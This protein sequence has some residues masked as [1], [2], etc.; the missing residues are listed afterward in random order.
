MIAC[1]I[2]P[3]VMAFSILQLWRPQTQESSHCSY[4]EREWLH[5]IEH[6]E[7]ATVP[8]WRDAAS[9][10][11]RLAVPWSYWYFGR[12]RR[13][14]GWRLWWHLRLEW[15]VTLGWWFS[16][17]ECAFHQQTLAARLCCRCRWE[18]MPLRA[19]FLRKCLDGVP[20]TVSV[21]CSWICW[22]GY[23]SLRL[24]TSPISYF[25]SQL[26]CP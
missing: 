19:T 12:Y 7:E 22:R 13:S 18:L 21:L 5:Q 26:C 4:C 17:E 9:I 24:E 10:A 16:R 6:Q 15:D 8:A 3:T 11:A 25:A 23:L 20:R 14:A 1:S 2:R